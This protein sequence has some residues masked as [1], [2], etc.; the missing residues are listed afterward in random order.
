MLRTF[1]PL[2]FSTARFSCLCLAV[3]LLSCVQTLPQKQQASEADSWVLWAWEHPED[4][5]FLGDPVQH[6]SAGNPQVSI[7]PLLGTIRWTEQ[8]LEILPRRQPL[9]APDDAHLTAVVRLE[10]D[11]GLDPD[12]HPVLEQRVVESILRWV[13][14]EI[15]T[16]ERLGAMP[17][18]ALQIDFDARYSERALYRRLLEKLDRD[19]DRRLRL[20]ITALASWCLDD[21]W[22]RDL[23]VDEAVPMLFRMG[24]QTSQL[25]SRLN[26]G[27]DFSLELCRQ[28]YGFSTD[29]PWIPV[30]PGRRIFVFHP[31]PWD[32][33]AFEATQARL[34]A[35]TD[36]I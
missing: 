11:R 10:M 29:E 36:N 2:I 30:I 21:P 32:A 18:T 14:R 5:S 8:G 20:G 23:P 31:D 33:D 24:S 27:R 34:S 13:E 1:G 26:H 9:T 35:S 28:S 17:W 19:L 16:A 22:I 6:S 25:R 7:A 12:G 4:F 3:G 15:S